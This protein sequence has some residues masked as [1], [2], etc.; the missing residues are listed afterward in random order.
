[1]IHEIGV[2]VQAFLA[3]KGFPYEIVDGPEDTTTAT[4]GRSRIVIEHATDAFG[5]PRSQGGT[6]PRRRTARCGYKATIYAQS[7]VA[8]PQPFEHRRLCEL[9]RDQFLVAMDYVASTRQNDWAPTSGQ[10]I[11]PPDLVGS[12]AQG[13]AVY[14]LAFT[15]D[16]GIQDVTWAGATAPTYTLAGGTVKSTTKAFA[17]GTT[18]A[19][20]DPSQAPASAE[21]SCG[22]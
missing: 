22:P 10:F 1:M 4:W 6:A 16:R 20:A 14:E 11:T 7:D 12:E 3:A 21:K 2:E 5:P 15:F 8:G 13:G 9:M 17:T 18:L 19:G